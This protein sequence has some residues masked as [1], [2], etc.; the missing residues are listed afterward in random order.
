LTVAGIILKNFPDPFIDKTTLS[1][2]LPADD[3]VRA[4]LYDISGRYIRDIYNG[5]V[6][7]GQEYLIELDGN[8]LAAGIYICRITTSS[9]GFQSKMI[10][11]R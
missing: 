5:Y 2:L 9:G 11:K 8:G 6:I 10:S 7:K 4:G 1:V 3:Q